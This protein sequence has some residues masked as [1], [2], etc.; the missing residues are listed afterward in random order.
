[1]KLLG[2]KV[3]IEELDMVVLAVGMVP[4]SRPETTPRIKAPAD[5]EGGR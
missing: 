1:M 4:T 3:K 5:T 2:E